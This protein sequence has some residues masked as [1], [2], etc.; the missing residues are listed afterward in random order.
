[1]ASLSVVNLRLRLTKSV[2]MMPCCPAGRL[3]WGIVGGNTRSSEVLKLLPVKVETMLGNSAFLS[4]S[5]AAAAVVIRISRLIP[6]NWSSVSGAD[7]DLCLEGPSKGDPGEY[8]LH[9]V[10]GGY[11]RHCDLPL[12]SQSS[13]SWPSGCKVESSDQLVGG[14]VD[15]LQPLR[16]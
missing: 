10:P 11:S 8:A 4:G 2:T 16:P 14:P 6:R 15:W 3:G 12:C 1:M 9:L 5:P 13:L 7:Q